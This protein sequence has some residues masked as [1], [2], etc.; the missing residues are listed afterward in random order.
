MCVSFSIDNHESDGLRIHISCA[1]LAVFF[2]DIA[3]GRFAPPEIARQLKT[4]IKNNDFGAAVGVL[5]RSY[6][7]LFCI[8]VQVR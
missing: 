8:G 4:T 6:A 5:S 7:S 3:Q 1:S 2:S